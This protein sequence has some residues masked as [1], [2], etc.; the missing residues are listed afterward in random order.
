MSG[1]RPSLSPQH[2]VLVA[3]EQ[4]PAHTHIQKKTYPHERRN[5]EGSTVT[6]KG[7]GNPR[8][9]HH[10]QNHSDIDKGVPEK[11]RHHTKGKNRAEAIF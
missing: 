4:I 1:E 8:D 7:Q 2:S 6:E 10:P 9:R 11:H 3:L 5:E